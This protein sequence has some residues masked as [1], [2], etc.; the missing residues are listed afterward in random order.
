M[1]QN[2]KEQSDIELQ[3]KMIKINEYI[4]KIRL[5]N[6]DLKSIDKRDIELVEEVDKILKKNHQSQRD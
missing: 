5:E 4:L 2:T 6:N 1:N 3:R